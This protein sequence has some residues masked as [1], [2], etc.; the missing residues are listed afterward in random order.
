MTQH[1]NWRLPPTLYLEQRDAASL[2][3]RIRLGDACLALRG[4][5][6]DDLARHAEVFA[7]VDGDLAAFVARFAEAARS[8]APRAT[9]FA[10][11]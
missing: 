4:T 6:A 5:Y 3:E 11:D 1:E 8:E 2:S 7:A 10:G 9:F